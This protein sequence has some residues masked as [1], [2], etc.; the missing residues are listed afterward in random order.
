MGDMRADRLLSIV[1]ILQSR[2][3]QTAR[4]LAAELEVSERTI[5]RDMVALSTA[6]IPL[7]ADTGGYRLIDGYRTQLTGF[8][9][10]EA[11]ALALAELPAAA[12]ELGLAEVVA[13]A[14]LKLAAALPSSLREHTERMRKRF[15]LDT[16]GWYHDGDESSYLAT[17]AD[18]VWQQ[19]QISMTYESWTRVVKAQVDPLGLVLKGGK[20]YLVA[21]SDGGLRTYRVRQIQ[22]LTTLP[23]SFSWPEDFDLGRY[24]K[25]HVADFRARLH[26]GHALVRLSPT[27]IEALPHRMGQVVADSAA[28]GEIQA[29]GWTLARIPIESQSHAQRELLRLGAEAEV[30][31]PESLRARLAATAQAL[32]RV[33]S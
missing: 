3:A 25:E 23:G 29:D 11:R 13:A 7:V 8:T 26:K 4:G 19:R 18:S 1:L 17:L 5:Y 2:G 22:Q 30:L 6:G 31:E 21:R 14:Q 10:A 16:P 32:C 20:W 12:A 24:W 15:H 28:D 33:Y 9:A 27:A